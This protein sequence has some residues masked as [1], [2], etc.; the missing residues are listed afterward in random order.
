M[1][2]SQSRMSYCSLRKGGDH[3][4]LMIKRSWVRFLLSLIRSFFMKTCCYNLLGEMNRDEKE[5]KATLPGAVPVP[6]NT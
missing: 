2:S 4:L 3:V 6:G 5:E 1:D